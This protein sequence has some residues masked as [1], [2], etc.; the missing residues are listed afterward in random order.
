MSG[1][2]ALLGSGS[3]NEAPAQSLLRATHTR[4][5]AYEGLWTESGNAVGVGRDAWELG[6]DFAAG[7]LLYES[8]RVVVAADASLYYRADLVQA[9]AEA[10]QQPVSHGPGALI[11]AAYLAWGDDCV[12]R[13]EGDFAFILWDRQRGRLLAARD[14]TGTRPLFFAESGSQ[15]VLSS[16]LLAV[17]RFP[18]V[19]QGLNR[20]AIAEVLISAA[21]LSVT[22]TEYS[23]IRRVPAAHRLVWSPG[24]APQLERFTAGPIFDRTRRADGQEAATELRVVLGRAVKERLAATGV[25]SV[26]MSGGYDSPSIFALGRAEADAG[27]SVLPV[28]MSYPEGD[29]GREDELITAVAEFNQTPVTWTAIADV[30][31]HPDP[32]A[33]ARRRDESFAHPFEPWNQALARGSRAAGSRIALSGNGGD[34]F[35]SVSPVFLSDLLRSGRWMALAQ[36]ARALGFRPRGYR[37]LFH[38]AVQPNLPPFAHRLIARLRGGRALRPHLQTAFPEWFPSDPALVAQLRARQWHYDQRRPGEPMSSAESNWYLTTSFG[39]RVGCLVSTLAHAVGVEVRS[40]MYDRRVLALMAGRP[41]EDRFGGG[42]NKRL[43]RAAVQGLLPA[44]HLARR[45]RR[46][47]LPGGYLVRAL[48]PALT[49]AV[50]GLGSSFHLGDLGLVDPAKVKAACARYLANPR[51]ESGLGPQVFEV[52]AVEYW[53]RARG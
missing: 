30:P 8:D 24:G 36:E 5:A 13:C 31:G 32:L 52:L 1:L 7:E 11:A 12:S 10:G 3:A 4:G 38:W 48:P 44:E 25:T 20:L 53:L 43:L 35:F 50:E 19:P 26:W 39:Q 45:K 47:G 49:Q 33:W 9:L 51:A 21:S 18:G 27:Q 16:S 2:I 17:A 37:E 28:S 23:A 41:R 34:Q 42:E 15:L 40:P 6:P 46:T 22:D 29:T 14:L